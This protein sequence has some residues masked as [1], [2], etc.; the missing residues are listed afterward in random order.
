MLNVQGISP[1]PQVKAALGWSYAGEADDDPFDR[2]WPDDAMAE[3]E[4]E[5][6][7]AR[8]MLLAGLFGILGWAAVYFLLRFVLF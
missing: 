3:P 8:G 7:P 5:L 6:A 1:S 2:I 4:D